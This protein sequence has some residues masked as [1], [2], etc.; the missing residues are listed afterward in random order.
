MGV[1]AEFF[2]PHLIMSQNPNVKFSKM[3]KDIDNQSS[4]EKV[5]LNESLSSQNQ[6]IPKWRW[7]KR[8]KYVWIFDQNLKFQFSYKLIWSNHAAE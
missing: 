7:C 2:V 6:Q 8:Y 3:M 1:D 5:H 4:R